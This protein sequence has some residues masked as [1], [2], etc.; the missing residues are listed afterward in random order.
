MAGPLVALVVEGRNDVEAAEILGELA[1]RGSGNTDIAESL[2]VRLRDPCALAEARCRLTQ[3]LAEI[4]GAEVDTELRELA[5]D[6]ELQ[7]SMTANAVLAMRG[8]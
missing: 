7:V 5:G 4:P 1:S 8:E 2:I 3:A 6:P